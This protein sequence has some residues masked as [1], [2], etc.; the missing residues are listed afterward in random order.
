M[1]GLRHRNIVRLFDVRVEEQYLYMV[2]VWF[3][4]RA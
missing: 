3:V 2:R 1:Q 4:H